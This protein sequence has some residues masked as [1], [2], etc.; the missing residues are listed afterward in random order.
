MAAVA[1]VGPGTAGN[2]PASGM[3]P[4]PSLSCTVRVW[5]M[6]ELLGGRLGGFP[7]GTLALSGVLGCCW[8]CWF[9]AAVEAP[10]RPRPRVNPGSCLG[11]P[12]DCSDGLAFEFA[13]RPLVEVRPLIL[14][15]RTQA[16]GRWVAGGLVLGR[17]LLP[18]LP[19]SLQLTWGQWRGSGGWVEFWRK[20][21]LHW[22]GGGFGWG[23]LYKGL[24]G[25]C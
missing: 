7:G 18:P 9:W 5:E 4:G 23:S 15:P 2:L 8:G 6:R 24:T 22:R 17:E 12:R 20:S 21:N 13:K 25:R 14:Q 19:G 3:A 11:Q 10:G 1:V 16:G